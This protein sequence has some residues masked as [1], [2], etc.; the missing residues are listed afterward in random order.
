MAS[1]E[2]ASWQ[3][4]HPSLIST[5]GEPHRFFP[6]QCNICCLFLTAGIEALEEH[7]AEHR[8]KLRA[9]LEALQHD[10]GGDAGHMWDYLGG[11]HAASA[12]Q[13]Q[14]PQQQQQQQQSQHQQEQFQA[15]S[16]PTVDSQT[17]W[18][19]SSTSRAVN[20]TTSHGGTVSGATSLTAC[21]LQSG[22]GASTP[23]QEQQFGSA[24]IPQDGYAAYTSQA[25]YY[26]GGGSSAIGRMVYTGT[27]GSSAYTIPSDGSLSHS[28]GLDGETA[29]VTNEQL[30]GSTYRSTAIAYEPNITEVHA[31]HVYL[32]NSVPDTTIGSRHAMYCG[33]P[34]I[35]SMEV[36]C[37]AQRT[38]RQ[39]AQLQSDYTGTNYKRQQETP[40]EA[41]AKKQR[42]LEN[43]PSSTTTTTAPASFIDPPHSEE[44]M[45]PVES[46]GTSN[47]QAYPQD[48][49]AHNFTEFGATSTTTTT[50]ATTIQQLQEKLGNQWS[51][52]AQQ[53]N[54]FASR[55]TVDVTIL[56]DPS[57]APVHRPIEQ[58][59]T[60]KEDT[61][62]ISAQPRSVPVSCPVGVAT[63]SGADNIEQDAAQNND[64]TYFERLAR[65]LQ[66]ANDSNEQVHSTH[67]AIGMDQQDTQSWIHAQFLGQCGEIGPSKDH[68]RLYGTETA[69]ECE[70]PGS[71]AFAPLGNRNAAIEERQ[72]VKRE[73]DFGAAGKFKVQGE[74]EQPGE[75][76]EGDEGSSAATKTQ[77]EEIID[78]ILNI[79]CL[80]EEQQDA[81][82]AFKGEKIDESLS[83]NNSLPA[84]SEQAADFGFPKIE[85][86]SLEVTES[87]STAVSAE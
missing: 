11:Q 68:E 64:S 40:V 74:I 54:L 75:E 81:K 42:L 48:S 78:A 69:S 70:I 8:S 17:L 86:R 73:S 22:T 21:S 46:N 55:E 65:S 36:P 47:S 76:F 24:H 59:P 85:N 26:G 23:M 1:H 84:E 66:I 7:V 10:E 2:D 79:A 30:Q 16:Q 53:T 25:L 5:D 19:G 52:G 71:P 41:V 35:T 39:Q 3:T 62:E 51:Q 63:L 83:R 37:T 13:S 43:T 20:W 12:V 6:Y 57:S 31:D 61:T 32:T 38:C 82:T 80:R 34:Y 9:R 27:S 33:A 50:E 49:S 77:A 45:E 72:Q 60:A 15:A 28:S 44:Q 4:R 67:D 29:I 58:H 14:Q 87:D 18:Y 56:A